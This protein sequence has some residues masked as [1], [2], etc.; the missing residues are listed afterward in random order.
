MKTEQMLAR[1]R[2]IES[3][4]GLPERDAAGAVAAFIAGHYM[5]YRDVDFPDADFPALVAQ[6]RAVIET[7]PGFANGSDADKRILYEQMAATGMQMA[8]QREQL[9]RE[10]NAT[11]HA[12]LSQTAK[13]QLEGF[14]KMDVTR[15]R[16]AAHGLSHG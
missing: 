16:I 6:M 3:R 1:Y 9:K 4:F 8:W 2:Q 14:L 12:Q 5:A 11:L 7:N 10:P 13:T 15:L